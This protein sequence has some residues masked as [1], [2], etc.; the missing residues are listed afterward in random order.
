[1]L[2]FHLISWC[3]KFVEINSF[4]RISSDPPETLRK[5][6]IFTKFSH[7]EIGEISIF[8]TMKRETKEPTRN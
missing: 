6:C 3:G 5:L 4:C 1:M 8:C 7:D 2:K